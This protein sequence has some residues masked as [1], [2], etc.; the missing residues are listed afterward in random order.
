[1]DRQFCPKCGNL[2]LLKASVFVDKRGIAHLRANNRP[3]SK[4]GTKFSIPKPKG[5]RHGPAIILAEDQ[6][7]SLYPLMNHCCYYESHILANV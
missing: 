2:S 7:M 1:M 6:C 5:G 4:R 3:I